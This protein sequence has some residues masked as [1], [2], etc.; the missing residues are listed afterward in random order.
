MDLVEAL[1]PL[2]PISK[3]LLVFL[4]WILPAGGA[5]AGNGVARRSPGW[6]LE[7]G[8]VL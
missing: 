4:A 8:E 6:Q 2:G 7:V 5:L 1:V 3:L